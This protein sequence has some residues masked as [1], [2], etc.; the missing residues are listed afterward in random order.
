ME[1]NTKNNE[2]NN[3]DI[4]KDFRE[5]INIG[6]Y[7]EEQ[8]LKRIAITND[9][10][11][12]SN[13]YDVI[14][15]GGGISGIFTAYELSKSNPDL[16]IAIIEKG[17]SIEE[18]NCP[19]VENVITECIKCSTCGIMEGFGGC[20]S[21][22]D[23]KYNFTTEFGGSL[24]EY[25]G[26]DETMNLINYVD[27]VLMKFGAT[28]HRH[29]TKTPAGQMI[30][31]KAL[32]NDL[33]LLNA[34]VKHL[35]TENNVEIMKRMFYYLKD[36]VEIICNEDVKTIEKNKQSVWLDKSIKPEP[37]DIFT[38]TTNNG[39]YDGEYTCHNLVLAVGRA[40]SEW[41]HEQCSA[42]NLSM[43]NTQV[44][45]GVRIEM[46]NEI[47]EEITN[48]IYEFKIKYRTKQYGD[49][50][51]TFCVNPNGH[52]VTENTNGIITVNGHSYA[53]PKLQ[54]KNINF[55][56]L[57]SNTFTEPF[58]EP[59]KYVKHIA[60]LSNMLGGG[61]LVQRFGDLIK[62]QRT[63]EHRL[64]QSFTKPTLKATAGD[65]SLVLPKRQID[66]IIETIYALDKIA[67]GIANHDTLL[68]G[69]EAK[70]YSAKPNLKK[71]LETEIDNMYA[72]GD[73]AGVTRSLSQASASGVH[74]ARAIIENII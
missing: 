74:V 53:D 32:E 6:L 38:L 37:M 47:F 11:I 14:I 19:I 58:N 28:D 15:I 9:K 36:K 24:H 66:N 64:A 35:G 25:T 67:K 12:K 23:G 33:H 1:N 3:K 39:E 13:V 30:S 68:Y 52:V 56:L 41:F 40:G 22:S 73:G 70:F 63:N 59:H 60:S 48:E 65:L 43:T 8:I 51:R 31:K 57:V 62:G 29:S 5:L 4:P 18:R 50:V 16:K 55:A 34:E 20:G 42:L 45:L 17:N 27:S 71:T 72:I 44:D 10:S 7:T 46:P 69:V 26:E 2:C 21:F 54:S 61:V 49:T